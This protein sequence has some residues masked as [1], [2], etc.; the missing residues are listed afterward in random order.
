MCQ[1]AMHVYGTHMCS[2]VAIDPRLAGMVPVSP[3]LSPNA[4]PREHPPARPPPPAHGRH[5]AGTGVKLVQSYNCR[6]DVKL[7]ARAPRKHAQVC[8]ERK[9]SEIWQHAR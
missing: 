2:S 6:R 8:K 3:G 1:R 9:A 5:T 7:G 4:L